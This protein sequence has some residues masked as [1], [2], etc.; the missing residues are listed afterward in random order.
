MSQVTR[1]HDYALPDESRGYHGDMDRGLPT[2]V[3]YTDPWALSE[4]YVIAPQGN[5]VWL[6]DKFG[7]R[8]VLF[9]VSRD[10]CNGISSIRCPIP[11]KPRKA[12][13]VIP[14][15]TYQ[16]E[17]Y[18]TAG[19]KRATISVMNVYESDFEWPPK[20]T[21]KSIRVM[22]VFPYPW[23]SPFENKPRVGPGNGVGVRAVLG[24]VPVEADGSA[25]FEAP[26]ERPLYFQALDE[27]GMAVQSM[28][29]CTYVHPGE[30]LT[31]LGCHERKVRVA[32]PT[33][34]PMAMRRA[35]SKLVPN[36][37]DGSCPLTYARLVT[38]VLNSK[39]YPCHDKKKKPR[40][41]LSKYRF[42]YHGTGGH[43]GV[44]PVH[45]GYRSIAG[46]FGA[47]KTGIARILLKKHHRD[48][49]TMA[50][51]NR[52]T[53][54]VDANSNELGAYYD[55]DRQR[56]GEIVWPLI[57]MDPA[58]PAGIDLFPG[59]APPPVPSASTPLMIKSEELIRKHWPP[60]KA[61][62]RGGGRGGR[63]KPVDIAKAVQTFAP[64]WKI[65]QCGSAESPGLRPSLAGKRNVLVTHPLNRTTGCVLSRQATLPAGK[66]T[67]LDLVVGHD[68]RGDWTL[69][70]RVDGKDLVRKTVGKASA[71]GGWM[72][73]RADLS[74]WAGKSVKIELV[75][76]PNGWSW[77]TG[78][79]AVIELKSR[80]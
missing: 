66:K 58:N 18:K 22:Q 10:Q 51:I 32:K 44:Q 9:S 34:R 54:Y 61:P 4:D 67:T 64:G 1:F 38:P 21:I 46:R 75:N 11:V 55:E 26:V 13:P 43:S 56:A 15:M 57:D 35:P 77:E 20:T 69:I 80:Q 41:D 2:T 40:P 29:S 16:G 33:R 68:R 72:T 50:E 31:C 74:A 48:A 25:Y 73:V 79:W 60:G 47:I 59:A 5:A 24:V 42:W 30:Q 65:S 37:K 78:H 14:T 23:H 71:K 62:A 36:L 6:L 8:E 70:V 27:N 45:G 17:R 49:L 53:L 63:S 3:G 19:H 28:R 76:Q 7:N 12:P 52:I 39:C